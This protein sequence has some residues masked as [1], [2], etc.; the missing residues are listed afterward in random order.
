MPY[1]GPWVIRYAR[2]LVSGHSAMPFP[3]GPIS[4]LAKDLLSVLTWSV[5]TKAL[6]SAYHRRLQRHRWIAL[7]IERDAH[8]GDATGVGRETESLVM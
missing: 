1:G 2:H 8:G 5:R 3:S 7:F 4:S 6:G